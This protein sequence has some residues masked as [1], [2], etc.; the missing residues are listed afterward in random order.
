MHN[1]KCDGNTQP[2]QTRHQLIVAHCRGQIV[3]KFSAVLSL[4][5]KTT[6]INRCC[7]TV[8]TVKCFS[9]WDGI[10]TDVPLTVSD[11]FTCL[12]QSLFQVLDFLSKL[13]ELV[14]KLSYANDPV[15]AGN[16]ALK[17]RAKT[18]LKDFLKR[19]NFIQSLQ[20]WSSLK[21]YSM[22]WCFF[23]VLCTS[24]FVVETQ[25]SMPQGRGPLVLRTNVQF[26]VKTRSVQRSPSSHLSL[27][28]LKKK[29]NCVC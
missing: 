24:S 7:L 9:S 22:N 21:S 4:K 19:C 25:P 29:K 14:G 26:S 1:S 10:L 2:T 6:S 12:A 3:C 28:D 16:P 15:K 27:F 18:L 20:I 23:N 11:R 13:D 17:M 5:K 8:Y